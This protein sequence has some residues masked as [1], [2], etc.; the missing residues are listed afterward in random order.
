MNDIQNESNKSN[1]SN[2]SN[3]I[4]SLFKNDLLTVNEPILSIIKLG[5]EISKLSTISKDEYSL[6][7]T[8][9]IHNILTDIRNY[10]TIAIMVLDKK[11]LVHPR[12]IALKKQSRVRVLN[13]Q[14]NF[15]KKS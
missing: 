14:S 15:M 13:T 7:N 9:M 8:E 6:I 1:G 12:I 10:S 4:Q 11:Q 5:E 2:G 3:E